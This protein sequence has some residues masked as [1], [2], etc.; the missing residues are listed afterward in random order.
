MIEI[1]PDPGEL[2][3]AVA[4]HFVARAAESIAARG[5]FTVA[6]AG[7]ST[8]RAAYLLL[9]TDAFARR[10]DWARVQVL[11]GDERCVPPIRSAEQL[12]NGPGSLARPDTHS[13][14]QH[15]PNPRGR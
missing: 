15:P 6:L 7:G 1:L 5:R 3:R 10:V 12:S 2:A 14:E 4:D 13:P 11:W 9:A 8:P